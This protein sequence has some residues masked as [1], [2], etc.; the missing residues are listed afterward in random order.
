M[1]LEKAK[2]VYDPIVKAQRGRYFGDLKNPVSRP[3]VG[4]H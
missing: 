2:Q 4:A 1:K 3:F